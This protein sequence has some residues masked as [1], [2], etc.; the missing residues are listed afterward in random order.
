[1]N[2][3]TIV[4][5]SYGDGIGPEIMQATLKIL[6]AAQ[7]NL[8]FQEIELREKLYLAGNASGIADN[9]WISLRKTK[10]LLKG[11]ITTPQG[12]GYKSINVTLR[13]TLGLFANVRQCTAYA[14]Y[15][16]THF[17]KTD[18]VIIRENEED[19]YAGI[20]HQQT[21]QVIQCLKLI[22]VPGC[23]KIIRYAFE[24]ARQNGRKKVTCMTKD[25]IM[26]LTDG[27]FHKIF[28]E[29][30]AEYPDINHE[31]YIIDIGAAR[32]ATAPEQFDVIVTSNLYG[33]ILSDIAAEVVGSVG[34]AG[35]ANIGEEYAMFEA[36]HG[37]APLIAG[38][39]IANPSGLIHAAIQ[40]LNH[41]GK[42]QVGHNIYQAW[43]KT[44]QDGIH[45]QDIFN[46]EHSKKQVGTQ[47]F[48]DAVIARLDNISRSSLDTPVKAIKV[49]Y[50]A[51]S[52]KASQRCWVG[53]D[54]FIFENTLDAEALAQKLKAAAG[55]LFQLTL[56]TNRGVK[57][58]P[59]GFDGTFCTDHWRCRFKFT[60]Q[61]LPQA[62]NILLLSICNQ[63]LEWIKL[64]NLYEYDGKA[65]YSLGQGE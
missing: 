26:K 52:K 50:K 18:L 49:K 56:I 36:I 44:I 22:S 60:G 5:I 38:K 41:L 2:D 61:A 64:E 45:T 7:A 12:G 4:S 9:A 42:Q 57:V 28:N 24:Y 15:I 30:A 19:L 46:A 32:L 34:I 51:K 6:E 3:K 17:P 58:W 10:V 55:N 62:A 23:E 54:V 1:M 33:D 39:D 40:M 43:F 11:P 16:K 37:S 63:N 14:P 20:E 21:D 48:A 27:L 8:D 53:I 47:E 29:I 65:A 59:N 35:S 13:K 25:N 31:H